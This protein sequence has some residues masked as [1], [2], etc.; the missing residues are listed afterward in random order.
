MVYHI[1]CKL[2]YCVNIYNRMN[3]FNQLYKSWEVWTFEVC[4]F[5]CFKKI[6]Q[7][8]NRTSLKIERVVKLIHSAIS[9]R[10]K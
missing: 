5:D 7:K 10:V 8:I 6:L 4:I 9:V 3:Y 1:L 2:T